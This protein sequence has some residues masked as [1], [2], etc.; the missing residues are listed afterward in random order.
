MDDWIT[1]VYEPDRFT[2][3]PFLVRHHVSMHGTRYAVDYQHE[4][5]LARELTQG[6]ARVAEW[7]RTRSGT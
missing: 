4:K 7:L 6:R 3:G 1:H 5:E 2:K